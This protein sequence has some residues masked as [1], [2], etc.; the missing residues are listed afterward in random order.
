MTITKKNNYN[1]LDIGTGGGT[2]LLAAKQLGFEAHGLE[3]NK[4]LVNYIKKKL[5]IK[6]YQGTLEK[7]YL[8]KKFD[9]I[10]FWDV[11]EHVIDLNKTLVICKKLL[12]KNGIL[13]LNIPDHG[14][15]ARKIPKKI[16]HFI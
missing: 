10:S 13:L 11:F 12:K 6:A 8:R 4:W 9:L 3:P 7:L 14:S 15:L 1:I 5:K 2:F 16:S